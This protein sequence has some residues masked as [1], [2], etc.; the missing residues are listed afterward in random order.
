MMVPQDMIRILDVA[1]SEPCRQCVVR[2]NAPTHTLPF[3]W[4]RKRRFKIVEMPP[5]SPAG[6]VAITQ[7]GFKTQV[8][9]FSGQQFIG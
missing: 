6:A 5:P 7:W 2:T 1:T 4:L 8:T 9:L 3:E